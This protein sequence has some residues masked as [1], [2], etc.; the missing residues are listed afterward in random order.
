MNNKSQICSLKKI[1]EKLKMTQD[2]EFS[3]LNDEQY[4]AARSRQARGGD[5]LLAKSWLIT[6]CLI[7]PNNF[8]VRMKYFSTLYVCYVL[9][10]Q[11]RPVKA[12]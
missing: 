9:R 5:I 7:F 12:T 3:N 2:K 4:L 1:G 10:T 8:Q 6:S 11:I